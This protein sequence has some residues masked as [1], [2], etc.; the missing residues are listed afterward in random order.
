MVVAT[1]SKGKEIQVKPGESGSLLEISFTS[2]G[3]IPKALTGKF[4]SHSEAQDAINQYLASG[5]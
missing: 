3:K 1:T 2:G 5:K 4:T